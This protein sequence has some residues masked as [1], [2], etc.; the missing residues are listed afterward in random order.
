MI[1]GGAP[2]HLLC[3]RALR[4]ILERSRSFKIDLKMRIVNT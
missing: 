3:C 4:V 1:A 2:E